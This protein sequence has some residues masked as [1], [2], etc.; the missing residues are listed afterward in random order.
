M[1]PGWVS[2]VAVEAEGFEAESFCIVYDLIGFAGGCRV[3]L[4]LK[5]FIFSYR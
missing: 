5:G 3:E 1:C 4:F 2:R